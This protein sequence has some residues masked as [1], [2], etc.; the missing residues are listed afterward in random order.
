MTDLA[1]D[2]SQI[3]ELLQIQPGRIIGEI[4]NYLLELVLDN[5]ELN[6]Y[7]TLSKKT[8]EYI[9]EKEKNENSNN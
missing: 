2:G 7:E 5:P 1:I 4:L 9:N 8:V 6:N 3:M